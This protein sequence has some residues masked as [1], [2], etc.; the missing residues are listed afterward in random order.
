MQ[1]PSVLEGKRASCPDEV[2]RGCGWGY[3]DRRLPSDG[4]GEEWK[5][6]LIPEP[7][8]GL[9]Y[10]SWGLCSVCVVLLLAM[11]LRNQ[12]GRRSFYDPEA[13]AEEMELA[14]VDVVAAEAPRRRGPFKLPEGTAASNRATNYLVALALA[15]LSLGSF[16]YGVAAYSVVTGFEE[17]N[18]LAAARQFDAAKQDYY[19][20]LRISP[21][22]VTVH[23]ALAR[24][25]L[26]QGKLE[27]AL[28]EFHRVM[29]S[30]RNNVGAHTTLGNLLLRQKRP[31]EA[32]AEYRLALQLDPADAITHVDLGNALYASGKLEEAII[33]YHNATRILPTLAVAHLNLSSVLLKQGKLEPAATEARQAA[34]LV[35]DSVVV[36][37]NLGNI[38]LEQG[39]R[40][41]AIDEYRRAT[42]VKPGFAYGYYN[43]GQALLANQQP[44]EAAA[45]FEAY[46][47]IAKDQPE[48]GETMERVLQILADLKTPQHR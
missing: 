24:V 4:A 27:S 35:P 15:V 36:H 34:S 22:S 44:E 33:E 48:Y 39:K 3:V 18:R 9:V 6:N 46:L 19:R 20:V 28:V 25:L 42:E 21:D 13:Y 10:Y 1:G 16:G 8:W 23:Y 37:N 38:L 31:A 7:R 32:I 5:V 12:R 40:L 29:Q 30:D 14:K 47:R 11:R 2:K 45:A 26:A 43:L 17:G 41:D